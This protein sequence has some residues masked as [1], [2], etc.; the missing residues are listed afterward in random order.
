MFPIRI[1]AVLSALTVATAACSGDPE[2]DTAAEAAAPAATT[3]PVVDDVTTIDVAA[4]TSELGEMLIGPNGLTLYAF[5]NDVNAIS[6]CYGTCADAWPPVIVDADWTAGPGLDFGI[7]ATTVREDGQRQLVAGQ[8]PLYYFAGDTSPG[9][10][11]GQSSGDVWFAVDLDGRLI[12]TGAPGEAPT[13]EGDAAPA[14]AEAVVEA[15]VSVGTTELGDVL[16]DEAG[17]T[18]YGFLDDTDGEPTCDGACADAWPPVVVDGPALPSG[19]DPAVFSVAERSDG[20]HQLVAG[21][22]PLY[23]F[24]GD[25]GP[26]DLN[27]QGSGDVWFAAAPDGSLIRDLNGPGSDEESLAPSGSDTDGADPYGD[28]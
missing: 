23:R 28:S 25:G 12:T 11:K 8:W 7:F 20:S 22:W 3:A 10:V 21:V 14:P 16:V 15:P 6:A 1:L 17:L 5:T 24:A 26:G 9:D 2:P 13:D 27:G 4:G 18:L 19:L